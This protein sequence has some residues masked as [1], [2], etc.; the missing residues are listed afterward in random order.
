M[1]YKFVDGICFTGKSEA[2]VA[3]RVLEY[4]AGR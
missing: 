1:Y 3:A 2:E 4:L